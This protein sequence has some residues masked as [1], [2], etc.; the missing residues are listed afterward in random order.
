MESDR[1][2]DAANKGSG[3]GPAASRGKELKSKPN[4]TLGDD[5][6]LLKKLA[7]NYNQLQKNGA[8]DEE[9][10]ET[11]GA[12]D[13]QGDKVDGKIKQQLAQQAKAENAAENKTEAAKGK[14]IQ[15][16]LIALILEMMEHQN[17][18]E[19]EHDM[20]TMQGKIKGYDAL[21]NMVEADSPAKALQDMP[22]GP[23]KGAVVEKVNDD[24]E[25]AENPE[26]QATAAEVL[27]AIGP[28]EGLGLEFPVPYS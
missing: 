26:V 9:L 15:S 11:K 10:A 27:E 19:M 2:A 22:D 17:S 28:E 6:E 5:L 13:K 7:E 16:Y 21:V 14:G 24:A 18:M 23:L 4:S 25:N 8:G 1:S 3:K 20:Q 12:F